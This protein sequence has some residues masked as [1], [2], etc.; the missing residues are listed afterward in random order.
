MSGAVRYDPAESKSS[1]SLSTPVL[2]E[3]D[4]GAALQSSRVHAKI[5][6]KNTKECRQELLSL[7]A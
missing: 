3:R 4:V 1:A 7:T 6:A 2:W 5:I